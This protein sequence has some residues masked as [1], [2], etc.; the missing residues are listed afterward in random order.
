MEGRGYYYENNYGGD[1][2]GVLLNHLPDSFSDFISGGKAQPK[3]EG[4][5][6]PKDCGKSGIQANPFYLRREDDGKREGE[7]PKG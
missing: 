4:D 7:Y 1:L 2:S 3:D 6:F 5:H